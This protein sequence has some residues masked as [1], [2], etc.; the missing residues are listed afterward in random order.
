MGDGGRGMRSALARLEYESMFGMTD[1]ACRRSAGD[2]ISTGETIEEVADEIRQCRNCA[3][4]ETRNAAVPGEGGG[5]GGI[6]FVGEA[7]GAREDL[8]GR[9][10]VG[11]AGQLLD[12]MIGAINLDRS[13]AFIANVLKC[14]PP[15][16]RTPLPTEVAACLPYLRRQI[17]ILR[18]RVVCALG[19][20]ALGALLRPGARITALRGTRHD[21]GDFILIP[22]YHPAYLLR[23]PAAKK[24]AWHDLQMV[25]RVLRGEAE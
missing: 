7:P 6:V 10:F 5:S 12:R 23:N 18:P 24:E 21:M 9:P 17:A 1:V 25:E 16:N 4:C 20:A 15:E 8:E 11:R 14:R 13:T 19:G 3:L 22:T 2:T